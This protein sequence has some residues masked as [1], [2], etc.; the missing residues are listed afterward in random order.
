MSIILAL[1]LAELYAI[2]FSAVS[3]SSV[4][5]VAGDI[6]KTME[7]LASTV[8]IDALPRDIFQ[9]PTI[10]TA[11]FDVQL[12]SPPT[13][14]KPRTV[15]RRTVARKLKCESLDAIFQMPMPGM[16]CAVM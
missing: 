10:K 13:V 11:V 14:I 3:T 2:C 15:K 12:E 1:I 16:Q 4:S 5:S 6:Y 8:T 9:L 7:Q